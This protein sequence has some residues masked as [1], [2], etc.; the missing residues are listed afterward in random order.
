MTERKTSRSQSQNETETTVDN[1]AETAASAHPAKEAVAA[2]SQ[3]VRDAFAAAQEAMAASKD[4][5]TTAFA[6]PEGVRVP[7]VE[8]FEKLSQGGAEGFETWTR[9]VLSAQKQGAE[10][11]QHL[12]DEA[13]RLSKAT[14]TWQ[15]EMAEKSTRQA[16]DLA[17][18]SARMWQ[19]HVA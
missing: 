14:M 3:T 8:M 5:F 12:I 6:A 16:L 13:A 9:E 15:L 11:A 10:H 1:A 4:L 17:R 18:Q 7:G 2:A 19:G